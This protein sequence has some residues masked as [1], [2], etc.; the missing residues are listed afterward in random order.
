[1]KKWCL[2]G[3]LG[4]LPLSAEECYV[5]PHA[6]L[7]QFALYGNSYRSIATQSMGVKQFE[8]WRSSI[9]VGSKTPLHVHETEEIFVL[10]RGKLRATIGDQEVFCTAPAT[11]VCPANIPHQLFNAGDEP[12]DQILVLG[13]DSKIY[14]PEGH[15]M[16]LPW[17]EQ[18]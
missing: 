11:L 7:K 18:D 10:L 8:M 6:D 2:L 15:E 9:G 16:Q 17:R 4:F 13:M 12:T 3:L 14:D 5:Y 1:M